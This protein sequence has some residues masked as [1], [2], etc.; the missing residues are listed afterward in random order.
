[1]KIINSLILLF[2]VIANVYA[3][4]AASCY[5]PESYSRYSDKGAISLLPETNMVCSKQGLI[6][7]LCESM[8]IKLIEL[9]AYPKIAYNATVSITFYNED[10]SDFVSFNANVVNTVKGPSQFYHV[11]ESNML[12]NVKKINV[13]FPDVLCGRTIETD[14]EQP[15]FMAFIGRLTED[16]NIEGFEKIETDKDFFENEL[17]KSCNDEVDSLP[18]NFLIPKEF[19]NNL[20]IDVERVVQRKEDYLNKFGMGMKLFMKQKDQ[21]DINNECR[22]YLYI[23]QFN[24]CDIARSKYSDFDHRYGYNYRPLPNYVTEVIR[25][26]TPDTLPATLTRCVS[27]LEVVNSSE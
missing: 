25:K 27:D 19:R 20:Y 22:G 8:E 13:V 3:Q 26:L 16:D 23:M 15:L 5:K 18:L 11:P 1:M 24:K 6:L 21:E 7:D 14:K 4:K 2:G 17:D 12:S 10:E 9:R